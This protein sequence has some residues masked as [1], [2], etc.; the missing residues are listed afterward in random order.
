MGT[1]SWN[2]SWYLDLNQISRHTAW[3]HG[4]AGVYAVLL[5]LAVLAALLIL[6]WLLARNQSPRHVAAA[7]SAG[8][9]TVLAYVLNQPLEQLVGEPRPYRTLHHVLVLVPKEHSFAFPSDHA[10]I[11]GAVIVGIWIYNWKLGLPTAV[12]G[13]ALAFDRVYVG[14]HYPADVMAGLIFGGVISALVYL[15]VRTPLTAFLDLLARTPLRLLV[16]SR[17]RSGAAS[18]IE[19]QP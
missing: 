6:G 8:G 9:A 14:A 2:R 1:L 5:G 16:L 13:L 7:I 10:V 4:M 11:A 19:P 12:L 17:A 3:A 18:G 15:A